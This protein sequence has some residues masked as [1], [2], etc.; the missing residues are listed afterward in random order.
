MRLLRPILSLVLV[1]VTTLL[2]SCSGPSQ[3]KIPT[4]Y[5]PEKIVQLQSYREPIA[6]ARESMETLKGFIQEQ[7][8]TDTRTFIH[9]P[10]GAL[11]QDMS[12]ASKKLLQKD[13]KPAQDLAKELFGHFEKIDA[14]A[15]ARNSLLAQEQYIEAIKDF[16]SYLNLIPTN[17]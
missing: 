6:S 4:V 3:A 14:A 11:R 5:S 7:N 2:V 10:F 8:W 1:L 12:I 17:N 16:D 9:G 15:K 13:Q